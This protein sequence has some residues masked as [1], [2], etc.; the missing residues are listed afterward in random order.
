MACGLA[1][2]NAVE[3]NS[4]ARFE[5]WWQVLYNAIEQTLKFNFIMTMRS[6]ILK[7]TD[8]HTHTHA[9]VHT[10]TLKEYRIELTSWWREMKKDAHKES[11]RKHE[12]F[13]H[14]LIKRRF[15][16]KFIWFRFDGHSHQWQT[17]EEEIAA[18][19][20]DRRDGTRLK[21]VI[22]NFEWTEMSNLNGGKGG[23]RKRKIN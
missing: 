11:A 12:G 5:K 21:K 22:K 16:T 20:A 17:W 2:P 19:V 7:H 9:Y 15:Q 4:S 1:G 23:R 13:F 3:M 18:L 14:L 10:H 8:R 6:R